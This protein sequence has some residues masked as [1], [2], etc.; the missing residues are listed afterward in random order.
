MKN[1]DGFESEM[2]EVMAGNTGTWSVFVFEPLRHVSFML[3]ENLIL[4][5]FFDCQA[6]H[7]QVIQVSQM[8]LHRF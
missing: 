5:F 2:L 6:L 1:D 8:L 3:F 4:S 7:Y